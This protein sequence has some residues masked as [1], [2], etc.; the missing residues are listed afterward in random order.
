MIF[1]VRTFV[2][3]VILLGVCNLHQK[4]ICNLYHR[5]IMFVV[6]TLMNIYAFDY[7][8]SNFVRRSKLSPH[9]FF[10]FVNCTLVLDWNIRITIWSKMLFFEKL[11]ALWL[12]LKVTMYSKNVQAFLRYTRSMFHLFLYLTFFLPI[13]Q[14]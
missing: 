8:V 1:S 12:R 14:A 4:I 6:C 5:K 7:F 11:I 10:F 9:N 2:N 3:S 13:L